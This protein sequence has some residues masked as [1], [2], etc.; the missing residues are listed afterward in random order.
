MKQILIKLISLFLLSLLF[1][2]GCKN[3]TETPLETVEV[4]QTNTP[5]QKPTNT[6]N[7]TSTPSPTPTI[8]FPVLN[9]TPIPPIEIPEITFAN[10]SEL[11][12]IAIYGY[13]RFLGFQILNPDIREIVIADVGGL[14]IISED[15]SNVK[16]TLNNPLWSDYSG[17]NL[18]GS[19]NGVAAST[20]GNFFL[21]VSESGNAEIWSREEK[22]EFE[23]IIPDSEVSDYYTFSAGLSADGSLLA[24]TKCVDISDEY[25]CN[26]EVINWRSGEMIK[27]VRGRDPAFSP[28]GQFLVIN[29]DK[30]IQFYSTSDWKMVKFLGQP[31]Q[32]FNSDWAYVFSPS[33]NLF[34]FV[35]PSLIEVY[36]FED[37]KLVRSIGSLE[38]S[39][40]RLPNIAFS[41]DE[42]KV[43]VSIDGQDQSNTSVDIATGDR[44]SIQNQN[45]I[46]RAFWLDHGDNI[47]NY[48]PMQSYRF[49][50]SE[51]FPEMSEEYSWIELK[52]TTDEYK[53]DL[54]VNNKNI[55]T[56]NGLD[57]N[58][59][60]GANENLVL[61]G[62]SIRGPGKA[63]TQLIDIKT[64]EKIARWEKTTMG[65][66][67]MGKKW[68]VFN[69]IPPNVQI[70][71][72]DYTLV[73]FDTELKTSKIEKTGIDDNFI[74]FEDKN[75]VGYFNN[76]GC[77]NFL[78]FD[79]VERPDKI[80]IPLHKSYSGFDEYIRDV[81]YSDKAGIIAVS[82]DKGNLYF[83]DLA[84]GEI[85]LV[86]DH[87]Y[88]SELRFSNDG[89][90]LGTFTQNEGF[91]RIWA[92]YNSLE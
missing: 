1:I 69:L 47:V 82:T 32:Y 56:Y 87:Q 80:C 70:S 79:G 39:E 12:Q 21:V 89:T 86:F 37:F 2:T 91:T 35:M 3:N 59:I 77:M 84:S 29:F 27:K 74:P 48:W 46:A 52:T 60:V 25:T 88:I 15:G 67:F 24:L 41:Q 16:Q 5:T 9:D 49:T 71:Q 62:S 33:G 66:P 72:E 45:R 4:T 83:I 64:G 38:N 7:P 13:P 57:I 31:G 14:K 11:E 26:V 92:V 34:A 50:P 6:P 68:L 42:S 90:M 76:E 43:I 85:S 18:N 30:K 17:F 54:I 81:N 58:Y 55:G 10:A 78:A 23:Y 63:F 51:Y 19:S 22:K 36:R 8:S 75:L 28:N 40:E 53:F 20:D 61:I 73:V 65:D 44:I